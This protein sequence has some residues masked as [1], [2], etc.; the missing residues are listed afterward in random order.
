MKIYYLLLIALLLTA[1]C[2]IFSS[3]RQAA[4]LVFSP[5]RLPEAAAG[6]PYSAKINVSGQNTPVGGVSVDGGS[7]PEG[8]LLNRL[9]NDRNEVAEITGTP[10][11]PGKSRFKVKVWCYGTQTS[12]QTGEKEYELEV[13]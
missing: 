10:Q 8:L 3:S 5:E 6:Q 2:D 11:K 4:P 9:Q 13:K 1:G 7:L 12:G